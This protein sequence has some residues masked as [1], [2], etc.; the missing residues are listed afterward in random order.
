[1]ELV[2][3]VIVLGQNR[4]GSLF[5]YLNQKEEGEQERAADELLLS[6]EEKCRDCTLCALRSSCHQV[7]FGGGH[8]RA[9]LLL[10]GE[11]PGADE[12]REGIPFIGAAG[13]LLGRILEAAGLNREELY[14]TNVVKC[15]PPRNRLPQSEE[16]ASCLPHLS[17]Q[18]RLIDPPLV[19]C[20]GALATRTLIGSKSTL[21][22]LRGQWYEQEG[23][24]FMPTFHPAALLRDGSKKRPVWE[25]F[26]K[27]ALTYQQ[28]TGGG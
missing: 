26:K 13:K 21:T 27:I 12:D 22:R 8:P 9:R 15:R 24:R 16:V 18:I 23:R 2:T 7:V 4:Q 1:M 14:I 11:A 6:L 10:V 17:E 28:L 5:D 19:V 25:D 20:L 3:G